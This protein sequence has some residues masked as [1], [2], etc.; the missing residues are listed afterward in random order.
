MAAREAG[1]IDTLAPGAVAD[2]H[3]VVDEAFGMQALSH[4]QP[5]E[6]FDRAHLEHACADAIQHVVLAALLDDDCVDA[7]TVQQLP[8]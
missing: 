2:L 6:H 4:A 7:R 3:A 5:V 8:E 1:E